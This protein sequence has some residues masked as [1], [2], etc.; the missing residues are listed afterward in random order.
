MADRWDWRERQPEPQW[1]A[2]I[3][4]G[5]SNAAVRDGMVFAL[6]NVADEDRVTALDVGSGAVRWQYRYPCRALGVAKPDEPGPRATPF[7][8]GGRVFTLSR[9][10]R[11]LCLEA[12]DGTLRW[13]V[14]IPAELG[15]RPPYWGFA[16]SQL[17]WEGRLIW[18]VGERGLAVQVTDGTVLWKSTPRSSEVWKNEPVGSSGYT[19]PQPVT[20][21]GRRMVALANENRW[22]VVDPADGRLVWSTA[23]EVPYGV[24][25]VQ[26]FLVGDHVILSGGYGYGTRVAR[27][28]ADAEPAWENK[29]LRSHFANL[30]VVDG[31]LYGIDGNQQDGA[32]CGLRCLRLADGELVWAEERFGFGNLSLVDGRLLV[33]R[34]RGELVVVVPDPA[35]YRETGRAQVLGGECWTAPLVEGNALFVRN[36]QGT[37]ARVN[38]P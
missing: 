7:V 9:D 16:G 24:T 14:D 26:P 34:A 1:R 37:L 11:L 36:R 29:L 22:I 18:S 4:A 6:G 38:L 23:W 21:E 5:F 19:T 30:A 28:G 20:H 33:L 32:R 3:G 35:G 12:A 15:E 2:E 8:H 25:S 31:H 13:W 10:G 17:L 27:I